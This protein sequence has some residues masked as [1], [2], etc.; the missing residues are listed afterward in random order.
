M[1]TNKQKITELQIVNKEIALKYI[2]EFTVTGGNIPT[3]HPYI[4]KDAIELASKPDWFYPSKGEKPKE[5]EFEI[6]VKIKDYE[7]IK[8]AKDMRHS[9]YYDLIV[10]EQHKYNWEDIEA[11]MYMPRWEK[12]EKS[13]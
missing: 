8:S 12:D 7:H 6:L 11:W 1:N 2:D 3:V 4:A 9:D 13:E 10:D 5:E